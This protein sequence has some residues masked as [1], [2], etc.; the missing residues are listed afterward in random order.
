MIGH[1][2]RKLQNDPKKRNRSPLFDPSSKI[3]TEMERKNINRHL[4]LGEEEYLTEKEFKSKRWKEVGDLFQ[5]DGFKWTVYKKKCSKGKTY[6]FTTDK[7]RQPILI[8]DKGY[9]QLHPSQLISLK[10]DSQLFGDNQGIKW[11]EIPSRLGD[12]KFFQP[13]S[14][15][16]SNATVHFKMKKDSNIYMAVTNR[17]KKSS[18]VK[19]EWKK[20]LTTKK[21]LKSQDWY[22]GRVFTQYKPFNLAN[23]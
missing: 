4:S 19:G 6:K 10:K 9:G 11:K 23:I 17:W 18:K 12:A 7:R 16:T 1:A 13:Q 8:F 15:L 2:K 22:I 3:V 21:N 14:L 5:S 20:E